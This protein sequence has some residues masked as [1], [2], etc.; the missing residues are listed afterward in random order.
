[1]P[2]D[3]DL[4][5][6]G[7]GP[8]GVNAATAAAHLGRSV[9]VIEK[10]PHVGG[11]GTNTGTLPSKTL[12]ETAL[13][14]SGLK[15]RALYGVDLS[16]KRRVTVSELLFHE[17]VVKHADQSQISHLLGQLGVHL[18]RGRARLAG[19]RA[20]EVLNQEG[21]V[22]RTLTANTI[23]IA[24]GSAPNRPALF[25]FDHIRVLDSDEMVELAVVPSSLAV[26]GAGVI[27]S[28]YACT[29]AALGTEVHLLDGRDTLLPFLDLD[30][31]HRL[32]EAMTN[33]GIHF[34]WGQTVTGCSVTDDHVTLELASGPPMTVDAVLVAAGRSSDTASLNPE[35]AGLILSKRGLIP[36]NEH[37]QTN[38]P[39]IYAVGDVIGFPALASTSAEQGRVAACHAC[40]IPLQPELSTLLPAGVYTIPEVGMAGETEGSLKSHDIPYVVGRAEYAENARGK[41]IGDSVGFLK[42]LFHKDDRKLLGV[43][44]IGEQATELVHIG[45]MVMRAGGGV[46]MLLNTC[47]NYPT[48]GNLYKR[49]AWHA[50]L[51]G[52]G[53]LSPQVTQTVAP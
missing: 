3:F 42:L 20:I 40:G 21:Q 27:G 46:D 8:A 12:R 6:L 16:L 31:S 13:A 15:S 10:A 32:E 45:L 49:A 14:L 51:N 18:I 7:A 35:S 23:I 41:I 30:V 9:A 52:F 26:I 38:V 34:H 50:I 29:F 24:I 47:F 19:S 39:H 22:L 43:H 2:A 53:G 28:E 1:M 36:V 11:A 44:V 4:I 48:L 25:P 33:L 5:V 17:R 37:F